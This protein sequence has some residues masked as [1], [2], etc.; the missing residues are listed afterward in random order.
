MCCVFINKHKKMHIKGGGL[1]GEQTIYIRVKTSTYLVLCIFSASYSTSQTAA[2][3][4]DKKQI[5]GVF[6]ASTWESN[7]TEVPDSE[8]KQ[9]NSK[10]T[11][12]SQGNQNNKK[13]E[14]VNIDVEIKNAGKSDMKQDS[15]YEEIGRAHV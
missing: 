2:T 6:T 3:F 10:L 8:E 12:L 13:C 11:F 15:S 4:T 5:N 1:F 7:E 9:D 14:P